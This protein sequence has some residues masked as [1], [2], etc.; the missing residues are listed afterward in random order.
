MI[1]EHVIR[2]MAARIAEI[3]E[4][5]SELKALAGTSFPAV[6]RNSDRILASTK[7]LELNVTDVI[8][9]T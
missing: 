1:N 6:E 3:R 5:A 4:A 9:L 7:M 2:E 8:E